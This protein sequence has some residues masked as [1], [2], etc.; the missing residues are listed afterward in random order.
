[1]FNWDK[2]SIHDLSDNPLINTFIEC[3]CSVQSINSFPINV[4]G[5]FFL[6]N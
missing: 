2:T 4:V 5:E 6:I 3:S 1:M